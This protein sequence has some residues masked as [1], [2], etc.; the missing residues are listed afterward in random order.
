MMDITRRV[1]T[2]SGM[3]HGNIT[4]MNHE[5]RIEFYQ[6]K[7]AEKL[8]KIKSELN[9]EMIRNQMNPE[10][11]HKKK[12]VPLDHEYLSIQSKK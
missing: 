2:P 10:I 11:N 7:K 6:E 9:K 1:V 5:E 3:I 4:N 8:V 12:F